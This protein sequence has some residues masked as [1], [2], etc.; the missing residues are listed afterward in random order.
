MKVSQCWLA[1]FETLLIS[2][3]SAIAVQATEE[4]PVP[5]DTCVLEL[6][7]PT[8]ATVSVDGEDFGN[9]WQVTWDG[10]K[11]GQLYARRLKVR[12]ADG[13]RIE[14]QVVLRG[15]WQVQLPLLPPDKSAASLELL[16]G[17]PKSRATLGPDG[18][19]V[20]YTWDRE[21][22]I[23]DLTSGR[24]LQRFGGSQVSMNSV[25]FSPDGRT[26][27]SGGG[28]EDR[29]AVLWDTVTGRQL[30]T[31]W[32]HS[33]GVDALAVSADG[34][35]LLTGSS[36]DTAVLWDVSSGQQ[37]QTFRGHSSSVRTVAFSGD[38]RRLP[39][40]T[41]IRQSFGTLPAAI[42]SRRSRATSRV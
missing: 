39:A 13:S 38:G 9:R 18:R 26:L 41:T 31:L 11:K 36:D 21:V 15:G 42:H 28:G 27:A 2:A 33:S 8:G 24:H 25:A 19:K 22:I 35:K 40:P 30:Q 3:V 34:Q 5:E 23:Q 1:G 14:R 20:A 32:G 7:L 37:L 29:T 4:E 16:F 12:L 17:A 10:L 6:Q